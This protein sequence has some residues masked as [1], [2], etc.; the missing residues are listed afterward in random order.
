MRRIDE[1]IVHCADT[2]KHWMGGKTPREKMD[3]IKRWHVQERGWRD[4]GYNFGIDR[5]GTVVKGRDLDGDGDVIEE[6]GA[7]VKG[8][9]SRSIGIVLFGGHGS[10]AT[11]AFEDNFTRAQDEALR[12]L[13]ADLESKLGSL[14]VS[15]H[16]DYAAKACPGFKVDRWY[17]RKPPVR[18]TV[19]ESKT[20]QASQVA[21]VAAAA[22]PVVAA[23]NNMPWQTVA[24]FA[25]LALVVMVATGFI[26]IERLAKWRKGDR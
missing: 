4:N 18:E 22:T 21:K 3:E 23:F 16:N 14:K 10:A 17:A 20:L 9:N 12:G 24:V 5:D 19:T 15:G 26:D 6:I 2:P 7:H 13:I 25:A 11:D 1:I 8:R